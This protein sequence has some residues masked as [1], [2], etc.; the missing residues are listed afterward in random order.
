MSRLGIG[1][2]KPTVPD[3]RRQYLKNQLQS[4]EDF[5]ATDIIRNEVGALGACTST[6]GRGG[7]EGGVMRA[8]GNG[9]PFNSGSWC[10]V[11]RASCSEYT[12]WLDAYHRCWAC[13]LTPRTSS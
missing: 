5:E 10:V 12:D 11:L 6:W 9:M 2:R 7:A 4:T 8:V 1:E 13:V 3:I